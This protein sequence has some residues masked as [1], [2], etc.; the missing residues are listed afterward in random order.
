MGNA[1]ATTLFS[2]SVGAEGT[3]D[4]TNGLW[5]A[6]TRIGETGYRS[7]HNLVFGLSDT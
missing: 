4:T 6:E 2:D 3:I 5:M 7:L 1:L